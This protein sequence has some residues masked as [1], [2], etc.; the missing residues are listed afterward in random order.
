MVSYF[1]DT[2]DGV[3]DV[4]LKSSTGSFINPSN[5]WFVA[6]GPVNL[7]SQVPNDA[8]QNLQTT[9][10]SGE[11]N[12]D[13]GFATATLI[14]GYV[15]TDYSALTYNG[16]FQQHYDTPDRQRSLEARLPPPTAGPIST[17]WICAHVPRSGNRRSRSAMASAWWQDC[18]IRAKTNRCRDR[19]RVRR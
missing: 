16:G 2:G 14:P 7:L 8:K 9:Q 10:V 18:A 19:C 4:P 5:P 15:V 13:L 11:F 1:R 17:I 6:V 3:G 12:Y